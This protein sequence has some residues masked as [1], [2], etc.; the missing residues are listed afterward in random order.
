MRTLLCES[1]LIICIIATVSGITGIVFR[2]ALGELFGWLT[3]FAIMALLICGITYNGSTKVDDVIGMNIENAIQTLQENG[4]KVTVNENNVDKLVKTQSIEANK[5]VKNGTEILLNYDIDAPL[6]TPDPTPTP[7]PDPTPSSKI[8]N[9]NEQN[10]NNN[11]DIVKITSNNIS[12]QFDNSFS[13]QKYSFTASVTG[14]YRFDFDIDNIKNN[15]K[16]SIIDSKGNVLKNTNY[17]AK[18]TTVELNEGNTYT[19][20]I[21]KDEGNPQYII[22]IGSPQALKSISDNQFA[23]SIKYIDQEDAYTYIAPTTGIYGI[24]FE[25]NDVQQYYGYSIYDSKNAKVK[26]G[27]SSIKQTSVELK[28][29]EKY[30]IMI[31]QKEGLVNY[32]VSLGVP[33]DVSYVNNNVIN[34]SITYYNQENCYIYTPSY[35]GKHIMKM[36][37]NDVKKIYKVKVVDDVNAT[38]RST[39]SANKESSMELVAGKQYKIFVSYYEGECSYSINIS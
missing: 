26:S 28:A 31:S 20:T 23:G 6:P 29:G 16:F 2:K 33:N 21:T 39:N 17:Y 9:T 34:G 11:V 24:K 1:W 37:I 4:L 18:G 8:N 32:K 12:G 13:Q 5:W 35:S 38:V 22:Y 15:Y 7:I 25:I 36:S 3:G 10:D 14:K 27:N 19:V 30:S